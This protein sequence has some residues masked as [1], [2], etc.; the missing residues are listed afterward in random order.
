VE[1][2]GWNDLVA[3]WRRLDSDY[4]QVL[5]NKEGI[6]FSAPHDALKT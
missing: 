2:L 4:F 6:D 5:K 1:C 3:W